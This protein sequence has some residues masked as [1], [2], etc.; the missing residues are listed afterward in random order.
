MRAITHIFLWPA[1]ECEDHLHGTPN[2]R[3]LP[4]LVPVDDRRKLPCKRRPRD[5][6]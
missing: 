2:S 1:L 3:V 5:M 6:E 4:A